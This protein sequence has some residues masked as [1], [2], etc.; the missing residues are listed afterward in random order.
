MPSAAANIIHILVT[1]PVLRHL[2]DRPSLSP[3]WRQAIQRP[4]RLWQPTLEA[5]DYLQGSLIVCLSNI[6]W[7]RKW[8]NLDSGFRRVMFSNVAFLLLLLTALVSSSDETDCCRG[9]QMAS[10]LEPPT[11]QDSPVC[12]SEVCVAQGVADW[13]DGTVDVAQPVPCDVT[14]DSEINVHQVH[15]TTL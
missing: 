15:S 8:W 4:N 11:G 3:C 9:G 2:H 5:D 7:Y 13:I 10:R 6:H 14:V 12:P 1:V